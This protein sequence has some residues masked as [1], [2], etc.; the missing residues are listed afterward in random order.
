MAALH[1]FNL[2]SKHHSPRHRLRDA[3]KTNNTEKLTELLDQGIDPNMKLEKTGGNRPVH[4]AATYGYY[5]IIELLVNAGAICNLLNDSGETALFNAI[6]FKH[7]RALQVL[8]KH[9]SQVTGLDQLWFDGRIVKRILCHGSG[10]VIST[11][12]IATPNLR[13]SRSNLWSNILNICVSRIQ[14][15]NSIRLLFLTGYRN[16][17]EEF[18]SFEIKIIKKLQRFESGDCG[19]RM[20]GAESTDAIQ[21]L[22]QAVDF[23]C[24]LKQNPQSLKQCCRLTIRSSFH[25]KC[26]VYYGVE[27]LPLPKDLKKYLVFHGE[28]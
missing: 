9:S 23:I 1:M 4:L 10:P 7:P 16:P 24:K 25:N 19:L 15:Y 6:R 3:V 21:V 28:F 26:N 8:L 11:L 27:Q 18:V 17:D 5:R 20:T 14:D 13:L 2:L 12:I 22:R